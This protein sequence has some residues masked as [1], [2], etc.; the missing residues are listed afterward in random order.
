MPQILKHPPRK[1]I[2][3]LRLHYPLSKPH[4]LLPGPRPHRLPSHRELRTAR[5]AHRLRHLDLTSREQFFETL[6]EH[7]ARFWWV[8]R[9]AVVGQ[10]VDLSWAAEDPGAAQ[11]CETLG[12]DVGELEA[13]EG[14]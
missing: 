5:R 14:F 7:L 11:V 3:H 4:I 2:R 12:L 6:L 10:G 9:V 1:L 13:L 8:A